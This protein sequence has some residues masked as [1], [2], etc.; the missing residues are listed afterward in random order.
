MQ[1]GNAIAL[2]GLAVAHLDKV[3]I[4]RYGKFRDA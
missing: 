1:V 3:F 2:D 4:P